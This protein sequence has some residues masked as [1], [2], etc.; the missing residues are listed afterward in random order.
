MTTMTIPGPEAVLRSPHR[1]AGAFLHILDKRQQLVA[2][3]Y[4]AAQ[5][6]YLSHRTRRDL[7]LKARQLGFSTAIQAELFR[8]AI[9]R[10]AITATLA[11]EDETTQKLRRMSDRFYDHLPQGLRPARRYANNRLTSYPDTGSE[12]VIATA[13]NVNAGRGG[14][15]SHVHGSEVA[16]W[17]DAHAVMAGLMQGGDPAIV[18]ESTP[19]GAR[20]YFYERCLEALDGS[21]DW[22]LHFYPWWWDPSYRLPLP[23]GDALELTP[24]EAHLSDTHGLDAGQIAWRRSKQRELKHLFAQEYPEDPYSCFLLSGNGYFGDLSDAFT[25]PLDVRHQPDHAYVAGLDFAQSTD[26]TVL[27]V[28]DRT[29]GV[30][31]DLLRINRLPWRA[32]RARIAETCQRWD[33][34]SL[35]GESNSLGEPNV[36][37]LAEAGLPIV[38]FT[39]THS[40]KAG[41]MAD[42]HEAL[43]AGALKLQAH[44]ALMRELRAFS[45]SQTATGLWRLAAPSGEHDD[46]VMALGLA[47]HAALG[48]RL[49]LGIAEV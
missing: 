18:L 16:F 27:I 17:K 33:V 40:S 43:H 32:M 20:G 48:A 37:A 11:H 42:L 21:S 5:R 6:H 22:A 7:I 41:L 13:G 23:T 36:E 12:V 47:W 44:P 30:M 25:A 2:L 19:N 34:Q 46:T 1:F 29:A 8:L 4:N 26:Y 24:E 28:L 15:Y 49:S 14:T 10:T 35:L 31:V 3:R 45:A 38:A 39:T 9:T